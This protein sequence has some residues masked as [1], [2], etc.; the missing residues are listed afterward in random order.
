MNI[1]S[2]NL[3][4]KYVDM[5]KKFDV[6]KE[7]D[8]KE[9]ILKS[10]YVRL[11]TA[12][13]IEEMYH[14]YQDFLNKHEHPEGISTYKLRSYIDKIDPAFFPVF[15]ALEDWV[16]E[17]PTIWR[18]P[19]EFKSRVEK[20]FDAWKMNRAVDGIIKKGSGESGVNLDV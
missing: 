3:V 5:V 10:Y 2:E 19:G 17:M 11:I 9:Q 14:I 12:K 13:D 1:V 4:R 18:V 8:K 6:G 16:F 15:N 7:K 20:R